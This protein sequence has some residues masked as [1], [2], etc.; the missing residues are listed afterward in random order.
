MEW[1]TKKADDLGLEIY[2][3]GSPLG[4]ALYTQHGFRILEIAELSPPRGTE[5]E[6]ANEEWKRWR[7]MTA[8]LRCAVLKRPIA[9]DWQ[10]HE[11][12]VVTPRGDLTS[13]FWEKQGGS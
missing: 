3:E 13:N 4:C 9:G 5:E 8:E 1:A 2:I 10:G 7:G 11:K 6:E 12:E